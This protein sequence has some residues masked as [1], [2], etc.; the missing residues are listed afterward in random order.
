LPI[1]FPNL[2]KSQSSKQKEGR[3]IYHSR[4]ADSSEKRKLDICEEGDNE[5]KA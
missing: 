5:K 4:R 3:E 1:W 2:W